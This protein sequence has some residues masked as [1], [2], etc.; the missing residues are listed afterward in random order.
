MKRKNGSLPEAI[1][2]SSPLTGHIVDWWNLLAICE[3]SGATTWE[4]LDSIGLEVTDCLSCDPPD[5][6]RAWSLTAKANMLLTG[7][8]DF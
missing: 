6:G 4:V 2:A 3:N 5:E 1:R 8:F 7:Q